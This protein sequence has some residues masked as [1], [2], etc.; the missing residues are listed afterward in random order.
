M[1]EGSASGAAG[2]G[3][4]RVKAEKFDLQSFCKEFGDSTGASNSWASLPQEPMAVEQ[5]SREC[6]AA[7]ATSAE[8]CKAFSGDQQPRQETVLDF[9]Q[10]SPNGPFAMFVGN[11]PFATTEETIAEMV[12]GLNVKSIKM[13][14]DH[15][16][17][18]PRGCAVVEFKDMES[19]KASAAL[20]GVEY[21][22]RPIRMT[23]STPRDSRSGYA[24]PAYKEQRTFS[25]LGHPISTAPES[26]ESGAASHLSKQQFQTEAPPRRT[27]YSFGDQTLSGWRNQ[28]GTTPSTA[29][30]GL[31]TR[32]PVPQASTQPIVRENPFGEAKARVE[33]ILPQPQE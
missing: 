20:Q 16:T 25:G 15:V 24:K 31:G 27:K 30:A 3:P 22:G 5:A 7:Q 11:L 2:S 10:V 26:R 12:D 4:S 28:P 19:L 13:L 29:P 23:I 6:A 21:G 9:S 14:V 32:L 33:K 8:Y 17:Q 1:A 18:K